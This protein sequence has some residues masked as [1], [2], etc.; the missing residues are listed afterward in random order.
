MKSDI[1]KKQMFDPHLSF[2]ELPI[3]RVTTIIIVAFIVIVSI[4]IFFISKPSWDPSYKGF[5]HFFTVFKFPLYGVGFLASILALY[6]TNH[7]SEQSKENMRLTREQNIFS[8]YYKHLE[9]FGKYV[10]KISNTHKDKNLDILAIEIKCDVRKS[11]QMFYVNAFE[12]V[13]YEIDLFYVKSFVEIAERFLS[14]SEKIVHGDSL[15][16][17]TGELLRPFMDL[18]KHIEQVFPN[19]AIVNS[20]VVSIVWTIFLRIKYID[21]LMDFDRNYIGIVE[22]KEKVLSVEKEFIRLNAI[23]NEIFHAGVKIN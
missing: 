4:V 11:H 6:A 8:N 20:G 16:I 17:H 19:I 23:N 5:N 1:S 7:R 18:E 9:E 22:A 12:G 21:K 10:E 3:V 2:F 15:Y 14:A 13:S